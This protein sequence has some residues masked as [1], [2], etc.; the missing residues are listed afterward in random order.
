[1]PDEAEGW[2]AHIAGSVEELRDE[3]RKMEAVNAT[4]EQFGLKV[5]SHPD[6]LI[7]T[8]RNKMGSG[9]KFTVSIGLANQ[10]V[11]T[12][13]LRVDASARRNNLN[14]AKRLSA[15]LSDCGH[16]V[17]PLR[18][19][20]YLS[21]K[22]SVDLVRAFIAGF[23][24]HQQSLLTDPTP[25][26]N[27]VDARCHDELA[28][29]DVLFTSLESSEPTS[30]VYNELGFTIV[31]Q[32]R[33]KGKGS[34]NNSLLRISN[35]RVSSRGVERAGL[36]DDLIAAIEQSYRSDNPPSATGSWNYPDLIYRK[37]RPR[38]LLIVHHLAIGERDE[39]LSRQ[40][41]IVAWSI[42]FPESATEEEEVEYVV[43]TTWMRENFR[44]DLDDDMGGD[45]DQ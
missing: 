31:C 6:T 35:Q 13:A 27:Y 8:A 1:M 38:P 30:L 36:D 42:S 7:V 19:G 18:N 41:P 28:E 12:T 25:I 4:P 2:Y 11:E 33:K 45:D 44:G 34:D 17:G 22:V 24:N 29:W 39:D 5:R 23:Q 10:F 15:D 26:M 32:R 40:V 21:P 37:S 3:F 20:G 14:V 9:E 16:K 43:N